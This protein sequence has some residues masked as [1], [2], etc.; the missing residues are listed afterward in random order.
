MTNT[1]ATT[2]VLHFTGECGP[3]IALLRQWKRD[4]YDPTRAYPVFVRWTGPVLAEIRES[5][6]ASAS[7]VA[8]RLRLPGPKRRSDVLD[9]SA[10]LRAFWT[11]LSEERTISIDE[12]L[13]RQSDR[14]AHILLDHH[15]AARTLREWHRAYQRA[16]QFDATS[17]GR[18]LLDR[19][20]QTITRREAQRLVII[21]D[22]AGTR[23]AVASLR[24][25]S[26]SCKSRSVLDTLV[27]RAPLW[28]RSDVAVLRRTL[29]LVSTD[30]TIIEIAYVEAPSDTV[31]APTYQNSWFSLASRITRLSSVGHG[32]EV[33]SATSAALDL[34]PDVMYKIVEMP[35]GRANATAETI[36]LDSRAWTHMQT[37]LRTPTA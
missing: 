27:V 25:L 36:F 34:G 28:N 37:Y 31:A 29:P 2:L 26:E 18:L 32:L 33:V 24:F 20:V 22:G 4:Y 23:Q 5:V 6:T 7:A 35:V 8:D 16:G 15:P 12:R 11:T 13:S 17:E 30:R 14:I 10:V 9:S 3:D 1:P 19:A 21:A